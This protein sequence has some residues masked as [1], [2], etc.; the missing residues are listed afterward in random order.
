VVENGVRPVNKFSRLRTLSRQATLGAE[1]S[2]SGVGLHTGRVAQV[3]VKPAPPTTGL[4]LRH[5]SS[6]P[7][8]DV[9]ANW[10]NWV[11]RYQCTGV[12][13]HLAEPIQ[14][15]E[16]LLASLSVFGIDNA[17]IEVDGNELP[18]LDGSAVPWCH[19]LLKAGV[20]EQDAPRRHIRILEPIEIREQRGGWLRIEPAAQF[21]VSVVSDPPGF[22][23]L[24]WD[25][26]PTPWTFLCDIAPSRSHGPILGFPAKI[27][28]TITNQPRLRGVSQRTIG[29]TFGGRYIGGMR[30]P[31]EPV[32]HRV[33]DL[34]GDLALAGAPLLGRV[35]GKRPRH[36]LNYLFVKA[37]MQ[38]P[39]AWEFV[40]LPPEEK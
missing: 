21:S 16:H 3:L 36:A 7:V 37:I 13:G 9:A 31:D 40:T 20:Q 2:A 23:I 24:S 5:V 33:L 22:G 14:T 27:Y 1:F 39:H 28:Y 10:T 6:H 12:Q 25:G 11:P 18:I 8:Q 26:E 34:L 30:V 15:I 32:R 38:A 19:A 17:L 4:V 35:T 29:L